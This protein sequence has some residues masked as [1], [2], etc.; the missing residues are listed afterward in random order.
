M[1]YAAGDPVN[2]ADPSGDSTIPPTG[3]NAAAQIWAIE[4]NIPDWANAFLQQAGV[5]DNTYNQQVVVAWVDIEN[6]WSN[7]ETNNPLN[8]TQQAASSGPGGVI[9]WSTQCDPDSVAD[10]Y[11][12]RYVAL[13]G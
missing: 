1:D 8:S 2:N 6:G 7:S 9:T 5:L 3:I 13:P 12:N 11:P 10:C 4:N